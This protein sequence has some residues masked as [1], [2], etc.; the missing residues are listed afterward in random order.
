MKNLLTVLVLVCAVVNL[1]CEPQNTAT[2]DQ[3]RI[4]GPSKPDETAKFPE[5]MVGAWEAETSLEGSKWGIK[6]EPDG[7]ILKIIHSL[8]GPIDVAE[9]GVELEGRVEG[10]YMV[11][12]L[13]DCQSEYNPETNMLNVKIVTDHYILKLPNGDL[14]G[15]IED[16]FSGPVSEDGKTWKAEWRNYNWLD[17]AN[18]LPVDII[19]ANPI[20]LVF[21]KIDFSREK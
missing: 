1:G 17:G 11:L 12:Q 10:A 16:Y 18:P 3:P 13:G 5:I 7:S 21:T 19:D 4:S 14:Q 9:G 6:F 8:V 20:P 2:Q 15:R